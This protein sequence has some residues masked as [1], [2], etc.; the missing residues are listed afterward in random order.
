MAITPR[1]YLPGDIKF[2]D[3]TGLVWGTGHCA[4]KDAKYG[5]DPK[6]MTSI[7]DF[8][9]F[10]DYETRTGRKKT[11]EITMEGISEEVEAL[12]TGSDLVTGE[13]YEGYFSEVIGPAVA[14][15]FPALTNIP[16]LE[17]SEVVR[18]AS[19]TAGKI[20]TERLAFS[21]VAPV[22]T[23]YNIV[24]A[25]GVI[26]TDGAYTDYGVV[27]YAKYNA[28]AGTT[29]VEDDAAIIPMM[30]IT[31]IARAW[32]PVTGRKGSVVYVF[33][34]CDLIKETDDSLAIETVNAPTARFN[35]AGAM[36]KS[37]YFA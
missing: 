37:I 8:A 24:N 34:N 18:K 20:I 19:D 13:G 5:R 32:D 28:A 14:G 9:E 1:L 27:N 29:L 3:T 36:R 11:L 26:T 6:T 22:T 4:L 15:V 16:I 30:D 23:T 7:R 35:V 31:I 10:G 25:T 17:G 21:T 12:L 2:S 33:P